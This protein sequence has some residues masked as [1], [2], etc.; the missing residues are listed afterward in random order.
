MLA[1]LVGVLCFVLAKP[2]ARAR[3]PS[4]SVVDLHVDLSYQVNFKGQTVGRGTG[5]YDVR[6]L[7]EAGVNGV[8]LPLYVPREVSDR[9]PQMVHL[10]DSFAQMKRLLPG[11]RA[12]HG[13][14]CGA[15]PATTGVQ[16][17]FEGAEPIGWE[18][19]SVERWAGRG[20]KLFGLVHSYDNALASSSGQG[21]GPSGY[22]LS[23]RGAEVVRRVHRAGGMVDISHASDAAVEDVIAQAM[24][25]GRPVVATHSNARALAPHPRNLSDEQ[26]RA[27]AA[28]GGLV[29]INFHSRFLLGTAGVASLSDVVKHTLHVARVAGIDHVAI[30]SDFEGGILP[31]RGL[32]DIRGFPLL[33]AA[34]RS[35]GMG[36][37]DVAR[38]FGANAKRVLCSPHDR[39]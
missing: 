39:R 22:G 28:T 21:P 25:A 32:E 33:A 12:Y 5:Q 16:F 9:G 18:L 1:V 35:A 30:G 7:R 4:P 31:A 29:G 36:E 19:G 3:P 2:S 20:I 34:L 15:H 23:R 14:L 27:V 11:T 37:A 6:W 10:E 38:V 8:I 24:A 13:D 26:L 17:A